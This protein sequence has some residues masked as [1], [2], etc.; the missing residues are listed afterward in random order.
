[1]AKSASDFLP[2]HWP[3]LLLGSDLSW[4]WTRSTKA[5]DLGEKVCLCV[6]SP[7]S[8]SRWMGKKSVIKDDLHPSPLVLPP[9][10]V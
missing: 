9:C 3:Q 10:A 7:D 4:L 1:M 5:G 6:K 8:E 2:V